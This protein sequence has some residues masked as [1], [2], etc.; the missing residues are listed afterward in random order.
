MTNSATDPVTALAQAEV[1][2]SHPARKNVACFPGTECVV[3]LMG[4][5]LLSAGSGRVL[6]KDVV[7][8]HQPGA[9][10]LGRLPQVDVEHSFHAAAWA[11]PSL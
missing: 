3:M 5:W 8:R 4:R 10:P 11:V 1:L 7:E 6:A 2:R 9:G